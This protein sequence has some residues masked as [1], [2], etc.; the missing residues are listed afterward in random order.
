MCGSSRGRGIPAGWSAAIVGLAACLTAG[1][2]SQLTEA[3]P[4]AEAPV[5]AAPVPP[6]AETPADPALPIAVRLVDHAGA[7]KEVASHLGKV[8]VLDCWSTSCPPCV[9]E[10]PGLVALAGRHGDRVVCISL[11]FDYDGSG[12]PEELVP[13]ITKF[14]E[15]VGAGRVTNLISSEPADD[16]YRKLDLASV[17]AVYI[18]KPN[19]ERSI[20]Y[21]D[22]RA[23]RDLGRPFNY[24]DIEKKVAAILAE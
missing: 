21:D 12:D 15:R 4:E 20:R 3:T 16:L 8:V 11:A 13:P 23:A 10:F 19:G 24:D 7:M 5:A 6:T 2:G 18:W 9:K 14:L 17:P 1:C 22:E